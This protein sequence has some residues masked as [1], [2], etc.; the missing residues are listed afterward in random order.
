MPKTERKEKIMLESECT[1]D[2][3]LSDCLLVTD[4]AWDYVESWFTHSTPASSNEPK[5]YEPI[6]FDEDDLPF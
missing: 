6:D 4:E 1:G 3:G 2:Y 5:P